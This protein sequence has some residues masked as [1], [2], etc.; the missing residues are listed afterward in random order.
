MQDRRHPAAKGREPTVR[1]RHVRVRH[2]A[3]TVLVTDGRH[4]DAVPRPLDAAPGQADEKG[5]A[6][7]GQEPDPASCP[8]AGGSRCLTRIT[9]R[10]LCH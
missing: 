1:R 8:S 3:V 5:G 4:G 2:E 9:M 6:H 10:E 7:G